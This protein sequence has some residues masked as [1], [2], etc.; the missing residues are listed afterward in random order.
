[1]SAPLVGQELVP[2]DGLGQRWGDPDGKGVRSFFNAEIPLN[3][4]VSLYGFGSYCRHRVRL[5]LLLPR[6]GRRAGRH[7]ARH[8]VRRRRRRRAA[9]IRSTSRSST[10]S[11]R[12]GQNPND[13]LTADPTSPSGFVALNPIYALFPGGY[14]PTFAADIEDYEGVFGVKGELGG[15]TALGLQPAP[16]RER[17]GLQPDRLD[18]SEPGLASARPASSPAISPSSSAAPTPTSPTRGR[19]TSSPRRST[20]PSAPSGARRR[21]RSAGR[22]G[23]VGRTARPAPCSASA[24]TASRATR[25]KRRAISASTAARRTWTWKPT[26]SSG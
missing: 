7:A 26:W 5:E 17:D 6:A 15:R 12:S 16:G 25:R 9:P 22:S 13:F 18:Q 4:S 19:T 14:T 23:L 1:M 21:T 11:A 3:E 2:F 24:R 8:A 20:S 10:P